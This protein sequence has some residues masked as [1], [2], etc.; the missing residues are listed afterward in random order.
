[1]IEASLQQLHR[2]AQAGRS[3]KITVSAA[4]SRMGIVEA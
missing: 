3:R 4:A 1:M 2:H